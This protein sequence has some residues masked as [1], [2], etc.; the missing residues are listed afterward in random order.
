MMQ[1]SYGR[2]RM[3]PILGRPGQKYVRW[4]DVSNLWDQIPHHEKLPREKSAGVGLTD[5]RKSLVP[6]RF[7]G[8]TATE[9][10]LRTSLR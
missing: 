4:K 2:A 8:P 1:N 10:V 6:Q 9:T 5:T 7:S 3:I